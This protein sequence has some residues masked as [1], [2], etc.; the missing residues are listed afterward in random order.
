M[1][2]AW[3]TPILA[4]GRAIAQ[5]LGKPALIRRDKVTDLNNGLSETELETTL[6]IVSHQ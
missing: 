2:I 4:V 6:R 5:Y 3:L 1:D